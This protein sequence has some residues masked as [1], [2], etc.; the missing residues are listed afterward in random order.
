[1]KNILFKVEQKEPDNNINILF[2]AQISESGKIIAF[3]SA[4]YAVIQYFH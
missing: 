1:M 2:S 4:V 3:V